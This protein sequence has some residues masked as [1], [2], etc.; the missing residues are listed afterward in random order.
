MTDP[1]LEASIAV[2]YQVVSPLSRPGD[3]PQCDE[4]GED[5]PCTVKQLLD[6]RDEARRLAETYRSRYTE[7]AELHR[8][9]LPWETD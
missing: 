3:P 9:V 1:D 2:H 5:W 4:C 6:Q 8:R 7:S